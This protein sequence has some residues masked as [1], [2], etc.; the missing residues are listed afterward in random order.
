MSSLVVSGGE[1][2]EENFGA[3]RSSASLHSS[4][5]ADV[6]GR[7][8]CSKFYLLE[9]KYDVRASQ[10]KQGIRGLPSHII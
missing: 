2:L 8:S 1:T 9:S 6:G 7:G 10:H 4:F 5:P 3:I